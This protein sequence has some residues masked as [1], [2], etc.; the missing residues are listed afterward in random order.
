MAITIDAAQ[1]Q[2]RL[3]EFLARAA[4]GERIVVRG[5]DGRSV[6]L[7]PAETAA[8]AEV[9]ATGVRRRHRSAR[10]VAEVLAEDRGA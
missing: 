3:E 4:R 8:T 6:S 7:G 1:L 2:A 5:E 9:P 10:T